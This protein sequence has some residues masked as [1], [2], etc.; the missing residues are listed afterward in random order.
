MSGMSPI[1]GL[2]AAALGQALSGAG[3][4]TGLGQLSNLGALDALAVLV[5]KL[6][7][8]TIDPAVKVAISAAATSLLQ[9]DSAT[10]DASTSELA[11][12]L[13]LALILQLLQGQPSQG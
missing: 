2:G 10:R 1:Q 8:S 13:A 6:D 3:G 9:G 5:N 4:I 7:A 12:V 11:Q